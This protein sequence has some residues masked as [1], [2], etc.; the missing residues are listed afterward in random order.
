[1]LPKTLILKLYIAVLFTLSACSLTPSKSHFI[2][3]DNGHFQ[4]SG[5]IDF[6]NKKAPLLSWAGSS[7]TTQFTGSQ[8]SITLD[9]HQGDNYFNVFIDENW[10]EPIII[11][12]KKGLH[13]YPIAN[14]LSAGTHQLT[15]FKRTEGEEGNTAFIGL[16]L[17]STGKLVAPKPQ[18]IRK[19]EFIGD[20]ITSGMGN[21][22]PIAGVD[23]KAAEKNNY[24][25][26]GAITARALNAQ[27]RSIS[28]SGIGIMISWFD[29]TMPDFFTQLNAKGN[30]DSVWDFSQW[31]AD[32]VV[33]NL[34]QNDSWLV[35]E[36][37]S[38]VPT[39]KQ[40]IAAYVT[41]LNSIRTVY[42][43]SY[44][45]AALGSMDATKPGS[46]WPDYITQA[47]SQF[48]QQNDSNIDP[49]FFAFTGFEKHPRVKHHQA[50]AQALTTFIKDKMEW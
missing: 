36:R 2:A 42:P 31:Q 30:N 3:A 26:Y 32:V 4:Y 34:F 41:F 29:F 9:D 15:L 37:L 12:C 13:N 33:V 16:G 39:D 48:K 25:A 46:K 44:I 40:R 20:S 47:V 43:N 18:P 28:Q 10:A 50:N 1:M 14:N 49:F 6:S 8:L 22:A 24:L 11:D 38:P 35:D 27:Y 21:E 5:R 45:V 23:N 17:E 7:V 19:I